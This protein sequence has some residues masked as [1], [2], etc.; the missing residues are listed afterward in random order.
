MICARETRQVPLSSVTISDRIADVP[1]RIAF[2]DGAIF[3]T[4]SNDAMDAVLEAAGVGGFAGQ[5]VRWERRWTVALGALLA[6]ALASWVFLKFGMPALAETAARALPASLDAKIGEEGM[7]L[8]DKSLLGPSQLPAARQQELGQRLR[9]MVEANADGH[10]YRLEFRQGRRVGPNAFALPSGI[11][12]M[13]DELVELVQY[14]EEIDAVLA[15]E[16]G[17]VRGRHALRILLQNAGVAA[18]AIA[19]LGDVGSAS[20]LAAA[21]PVMLVQAKYSRDFE[22]EADAYARKWL[23]ARGLPDT[24]FDALLCR[25]AQANEPVPYLS[26][27]PPLD[28]RARCVAGSQIA[29]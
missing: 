12:V 11:I 28:E 6:V 27:H 24:H 2:S 16:I 7:Q 22:R 23:R 21:V 3:E 25:L 5:L 13:T 15:H 19:V 1:R 10:D 8:L 9:R 26:S 14:D 20:S 18:L 29:P 4:P 17:H